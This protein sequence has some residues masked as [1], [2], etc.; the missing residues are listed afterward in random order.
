M[1][2]V[3]EIC[4]GETAAKKAKALKDHSTGHRSVDILRDAPK[5]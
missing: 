5:L 2:N 4:D 1:F 3:I